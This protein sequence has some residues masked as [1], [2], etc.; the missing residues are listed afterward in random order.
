MY[1]IYDF[2]VLCENCFKV[3]YNYQENNE[4]EIVLS[5]T[6]GLCDKCKKKN[7]YVISLQTKFAI[8]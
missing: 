5:S 4:E 6:L 7:H 2:E 1:E 3:K 8:I